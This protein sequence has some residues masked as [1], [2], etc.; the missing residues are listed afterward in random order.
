MTQLSSRPPARTQAS[1]QAVPT[2]QAL[3]GLPRTGLTPQQ[4]LEALARVQDQ[5]EQRVRLGLQLFKAAEAHTASHQQILDEITAE[6]QTFRDELS[7]DVTRRLHAFDQWIDQMDDT[8]T[9]SFINLEERIDAVEQRL[10]DQQRHLEKMV[11]QTQKMLDQATALLDGQGVAPVLVPADD[12]AAKHA[13]NYDDEPAA[14][15]TQDIRSF[16]KPVPPV[17]LTGLHQPSDTSASDASSKNQPG[18]VNANNGAIAKPVADVADVADNEESAD[19]ND[20]DNQ[21]PVC[22]TVSYAD[23]LDRIYASRKQ[24]KQ[25]K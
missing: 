7:K 10:G 25:D 17:K 16:M 2:R 22:Q 5:A 13:A 11:S 21:S 6:R 1:P 23:I 20:A 14:V 3:P 18:L 4:Q 24:I 9:Q 8:F 12:L 19:S 15:V